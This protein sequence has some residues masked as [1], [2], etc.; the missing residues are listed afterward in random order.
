MKKLYLIL[1]ACF[2]LSCKN[3]YEVKNQQLIKQIEE[4]RQN[5]IR[6]INKLKQLESEFNQD[7]VEVVKEDS[8]S[9]IYQ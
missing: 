1:I 9:T 6:L 8:I 7:C 5:N 3:D 2:L 4:T